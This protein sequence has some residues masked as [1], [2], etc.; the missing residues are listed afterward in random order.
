MAADPWNY[1]TIICTTPKVPKC[2]YALDSHIKILWPQTLLTFYWL[3]CANDYEQIS[4]SRRGWNWKHC[5]CHPDI[6]L[7]W[8][9][10]ESCKI[11]GWHQRITEKYCNAT[12]CSSHQ[13][14][15]PWTVLLCRR[16]PKTE[17]SI[18]QANAA[19]SG[20]L[21]FFV[22]YLGERKFLSLN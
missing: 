1:I 13:K 15:R 12:V 11:Y 22:I 4:S 20:F 6:T 19:V 8:G 14:Q 3:W 2:C 10:K 9:K 17:A 16:M 21:P 5:C 18:T 7:E